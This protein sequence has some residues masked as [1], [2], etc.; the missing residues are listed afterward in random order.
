MLYFCKNKP[1][2]LKQGE[3]KNGMI[4]P[5]LIP[6]RDS[7]G[8]MNIC[9]FTTDDKTIGLPIEPSLIKHKIERYTFLA[10]FGN[11]KYRA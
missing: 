3:I 5:I 1:C 10:C 4:F 2:Y 8:A 9:N 11:F 7:A 6:L